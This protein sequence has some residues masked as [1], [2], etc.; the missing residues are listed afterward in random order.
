MADR[1]GGIPVEQKEQLGQGAVDRFSGAPAELKAP[2]PR[3]ITA[4]TIFDAAKES[5]SGSKRIAETPELGTLPEF[6]QTDE[7]VNIKAAVGLMSTFDQKAQQEIL[8]N[9]LPEA[10][11]ETTPDGSVIIDTPNDQGGRTRSVLNRPGASAQDAVTA[12]A[13]VL[14]FIP[15]AKTAQLA[16]GLFTKFGLGALTAGVTEQGLQE[17]GMALGREERAP[18][19]TGIA[20]VTGGLAEVAV[21]AIQSFRGA[22][23]AK[24]FGVGEESIE[25]AADNVARAREA[26]TAVDVPIF[27]AQQTLD[28]SALDDMA[29]MTTQPSGAPSAIKGLRLQNQKATDAVNRFMDDLAPP[30]AIETG[31]LKF[32]KAAEDAVDAAKAIRKERTDPLYKAAYE[33]EQAVDVNPVRA[34]IAKKLEVLPETSEKFKALAE[35]DGLITS[36]NGKRQ[37]LEFLHEAKLEIDRM[38]NNRGIDSVS[39]GTKRELVKVQKTLLKQ[40]EDTN[41]SYVK[42]AKAFALESPAVEA[43]ENSILGKVSKL[44]D[45]QL[46]QIS[47]IIY[48]P[49][50]VNPHAI[51]NAKAAIQKVDPDA[52]RE[53]TRIE[54][55]RRIGAMKSTGEPGSVENIPGQLFRS[56]FTNDKT[57]RVLMNGMDDEG[58]KNLAYLR[59]A[60]NR[61][62]LGRAPGSPTAGREETKKRMKSGIVNSIRNMFRK[63]IDSA[64]SIGEDVAFEAEAARMSK[65]LF[66]P[67]W[68]DQMS[69]LRK[70][71]PNT[72]AAARAMTQLLNDIEISEQ[73]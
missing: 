5:F 31:Q 1:W 41:P 23:Q 7:S 70:L 24:R 40:I 20:A 21:P 68:K 10:I 6:V 50:N 49:E 58:R 9:A 64:A 44:D 61:A 35:V 19:D 62:K 60:L 59:T 52:W 43:V 72:P 51:R 55:E 15:A 22:R 34:A 3:E 26:S 11:F 65:M 28:P 27:K 39:R 2:E 4:G 53:I 36:K 47:K 38:I 16:K 25:L 45:T 32:K 57:T 18:L 12:I 46:K 29:F 69:A 14:A 8:Q 63:P 17:A 30:S 54:F 33:A 71:N 56:I 67:D 66:D 73:E 42:A 48:D 13:Q 37:S